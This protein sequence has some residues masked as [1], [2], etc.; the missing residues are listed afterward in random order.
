MYAYFMKRQT[1]KFPWDLHWESKTYPS[2]RGLWRIQNAWSRFG[3]FLG[4]KA[5]KLSDHTLSL[6]GDI[7]TY[8]NIGYIFID[9]YTCPE[10]E[11]HNSN[12]HIQESGAILSTIVLNIHKIVLLSKSSIKKLSWI[13]VF[14]NLWIEFAWFLVARSPWSQNTLASRTTVQELQQKRRCSAMKLIPFPSRLR[15][16]FG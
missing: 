6:Q 2:Q 13:H 4:P 10:L 1:S 16:L 5:L 11:Q 9:K 3:I 15:W 8:I 12:N 14:T 7:Y